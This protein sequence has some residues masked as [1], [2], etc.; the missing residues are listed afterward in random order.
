MITLFQLPTVGLELRGLAGSPI[1]TGNIYS[2]ILPASLTRVASVIKQV[3]RDEVR[4]VDLRVTE[5]HRQEPYKVFQWEGF[6][7]TAMRIG[8]AFENADIVIRISQFIGLSCHFAYEFQV[9]RDFMAHAKRVNPSVRIVVGGADAIIRPGAYRRAG[10]DV[11][12]VE[13]NANPWLFSKD[14]LANQNPC[15]LRDVAVRPALDKLDHLAQYTDSHDGPVAEDIPMPIGFTYFSRGCSREC[16]FCDMRRTAYEVLDLDACLAMLDHYKRAGIRTIN[17]IDDNLLLWTKRPRGREELM[18]VFDRMRWLGFVWEFPNGLEIGLLLDRQGRIDYPLLQT[19]FC[20]GTDHHIGERVGAY[21]L[22]FPV[23]TFTG[24]AKYKKLLIDKDQ[25]RVLEALLGMGIPEITFGIIIF[26]NASEA[27][28]RT[29]GEGYREL[30]KVV[31]ESGTTKARYGIFHLIPIGKYRNMPTKYSLTDFPEGW[32]FYTPVYDG[33]NFSARELF[34]RRLQLT[35]EVDP[36]NY[37][38]LLQGR[39]AYS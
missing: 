19:L 34:L 6:T 1:F 39:Y 3:L 20:G 11:V 25:R 38:A 21:R 4:I 5:P 35:A 32:N 28:F 2:R 36:I 30:R 24:R 13:N 31:E 16:A 10:A 27:S 8:A 9:A 22:Y 37:S 12:C 7:I 23:E 14:G 33:T 29:V 18:K 17:I 15:R 26:P